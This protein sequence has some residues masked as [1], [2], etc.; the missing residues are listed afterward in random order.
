L[1]ISA[2]GA[3]PLSSILLLSWTTAV[4][5][6]RLRAPRPRRR[7]L[8]SQPGFLAGVAAVLAIAWKGLGVGLLVVAELVMARPGLV[9][10]I[11]YTGVLSTMLMLLLG[12]QIAPTPASIGG[13]VALVWL[14]TWAGGRCRPEPSWIDRSGRVLGA[15]W[16]CGSLLEIFV[17]MSV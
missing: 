6:L 16:M 10:S 8:W 12:P 4:L 14:V 3:I 2:L 17:A 15:V 1:W 13:A 5:L 9:S 7:R 11:D